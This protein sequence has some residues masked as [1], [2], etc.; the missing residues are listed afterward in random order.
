MLF[1]LLWLGV[2]GFIVGALGRLLVPGPNRMTMTL[3]ILIG[4]VGSYV[5]GLVGNALFGRP[6]GFIWAVLVAALLVW[7]IDGSRVRRSMD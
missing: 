5:G 3:T 7:L 1:M 2:V 4:L 6:W